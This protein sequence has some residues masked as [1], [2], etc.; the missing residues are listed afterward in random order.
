M[1]GSAPGAGLN[2]GTVN[3]RGG[4]RR[5]AL[6]LGIVC[7]FGGLLHAQQA[8]GNPKVSLDLGSVTVWLGM[9]K[10]DALS[11][12]QLA[13]YTVTGK[14]SEETM[15]VVGNSTTYSVAFKRGR[16][17]FAGRE[18]LTSSSDELDAV[19]NALAALASHGAS[20]C[21]IAHQ[22]L[23]SPDTSVDRVFVDC[24]ER[25]VLLAKGKFTGFRKHQI[26]DG[27]RANR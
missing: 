10:T 9:Q 22:P 21:A 11:A 14:P 26:C 25:S 5:L 27:F 6:L 18:W 20:S 4:T 1:I 13:G 8:D 19:L 17:S 12:F 24:G 7:A 15:F 23:S 2:S 16:L 3:L